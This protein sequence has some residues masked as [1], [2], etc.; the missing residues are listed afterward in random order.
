MPDEAERAVR[1]GSA[2]KK[3]FEQKPLVFAFSLIFCMALT[4]SI[5]L[6]GVFALLIFIW[7][8]AAERHSFRLLPR[9]LTATLSVLLPIVVYLHYKTLLGSEESTTLLLGLS[10]LK[11]MDYENERDHKFLILIGFIM[12]CLKPLYSLDL[13]W[14]VPTLLAFLSLWYSLLSPTIRFPLRFLLQLFLFSIPMGLV[15]FLGF[16]R[17]VVPWA[18]SQGHEQ[19][20]MGFSDQLNPGAV[21]ELAS[22]DSMAFRVKFLNDVML[23]NSLYWRGSVLTLS[24]GLRWLPKRQ[25]VAQNVIRPLVRMTS[26][27][28]ILEPGSKGYI[29]MLDKPW[30]ATSDSSPIAE[31]EGG[32]FKTAQNFSKSMNYHA[33]SQNIE[34]LSDK[35]DETDL[36]IPP[37]TGK[38]QQWVQT[39]RSKYPKPQDRLEQLAKFFSSSNFVYTLKPGTYVHNDLENFLFNRRKGF[40]EH[41]AGGYATLARALG[42]PSRVVIGYQ[43]GSY[44][45]Y[46]DFWRVSQHDAHAWVEIYQDK[47]WQRVDPT[48]WV[49]PLRLT[50]GADIFFS[51]S[52][53]QQVALAHSTKWRP[54]LEESETRKL[55]QLFTFWLDD[56]NFRWNGFL[57]DFDRDSQAG[58]WTFIVEHLLPL[59][60]GLILFVVVFWLG[61]NFYN[62]KR[63]KKSDLQ[64]LV[65]NIFAWAGQ[66]DLQREVSETPLQFLHRLA[67]K[68][69]DQAQVLKDVQ[70]VYERISYQE[71]DLA[72][73]PKKLLKEWRNLNASF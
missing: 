60:L 19:E 16:P 20:T 21:A 1:E 48:T 4:D 35:I 17:I 54:S 73:A 62:L 41:F 3:F 50:L 57:V 26:Y 58:I 44:N 29:F 9:P 24:E 71:L 47:K 65:E 8:W 55:W 39:I 38:V 67:Q 10:A 42:I 28:V 22:Q 31:F 61:F 25:Q 40:C 33:Y 64:I 59:T 46:G 49:A 34:N 37:L 56:I 68:F 18:M 15:L 2:L 5:L 51:L 11:I 12:V 30:R 63:K 32:I 70:A 72:D 36:Q 13:Y 53:T 69:P 45:P 14:V 43:G 6:M 52:E 27:D 7:K 66:H 23:E